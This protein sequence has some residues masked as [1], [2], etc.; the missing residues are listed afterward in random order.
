MPRDS[1]STTEPASD[2]PAFR[3]AAVVAAYNAQETIERTLSTLAADP[4]VHRIIVV[5]DGSTDRTGEIIDRLADSASLGG[6]LSLAEQ[7][8]AGP[9]SARNRGIDIALRDDGISHVVFV[10]ADDAWVHTAGDAIGK[11][12]ALH[13]STAVVVGG[14]IERWSHDSDTERRVIPPRDLVGHAGDHRW[15]VFEPLPFFGASGMVVSRA[16]LTAGERFDPALRICEDRD[17]ACRAL[18]HGPLVI[19]EDVLLSVTVYENGGNLTGA[20]H[21]HRWLED[22]LVMVTKHRA[23]PGASEPLRRQTDWLLNHAMR[24]VGRGAVEPVSEDTWNRYMALYR[25]AGW[26]RPWKALRRRWVHGSIM[27]LFDR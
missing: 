14:R 21:L 8:N 9:S 25:E 7:S 2:S 3:L 19:L 16:V 12:V 22:H 4:L 18:A 10:D 15:R 20:D 26:G 5:N 17:F 6:R 13:P 23:V 1:Q 24:L 11:A 27:R